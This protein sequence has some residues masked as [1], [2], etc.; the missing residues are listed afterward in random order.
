[1][2]QR[3]T[4]V[5]EMEE[6]IDKS[7]DAIQKDFETDLA[8][9]GDHSPFERPVPRAEQVSRYADVRDDPVAWI[10][11]IQREGGGQKGREAALAY[12][13]DLEPEWLKLAEDVNA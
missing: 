7:V 10:A 13:R 2:A 12:Y 8:L 9:I 4:M 6:D 11:I 5:D 1:M 3:R